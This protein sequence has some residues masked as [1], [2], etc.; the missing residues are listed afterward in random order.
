MSDIFREVD[1]ELRR[2]QFARLW[3]RYGTAIIAVAVAIVAATAGVVAWNNWRQANAEAETA[4]LVAAFQSGG[5]EAGSDA[6]IAVADRLAAFAA[7]AEEARA[8]LARFR[9]AALRAEAGQRDEAILIYD[10]LASSGTDPVYRDLAVLLGVMHRVDDGDPPELRARLRPLTAAGGAWRHT[11]RELDA[12]L[13]VRAGDR[14]A[15][16]ALFEELSADESAPPGVRE[17]A[18]EL[19]GAYAEEQ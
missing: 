19:A 3:K 10:A 9:E 15:A 14:A 16:A 7:D 8:R 11:A 13:A 2:D 4:R 12:V 17:R 18:S 1:E 6:G 5:G